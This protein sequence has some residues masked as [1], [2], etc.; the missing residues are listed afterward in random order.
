MDSVEKTD[1]PW[2]YELLWARTRSYAAKI[3][4][5]KEGHKLSLQYHQRKEETMLL[6]S[7]RM[8]LVLEDDRGELRE[9]YVEPGESHHIPA[10][11]RHRMIALKDCEVFEVSTNDLDDVVRIEDAYGRTAQPL[12]RS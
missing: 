8:L 1:K 7:G 9:I 6:Y 12:Q 5:I 11:R 3:L 4:H 10:G 2:G